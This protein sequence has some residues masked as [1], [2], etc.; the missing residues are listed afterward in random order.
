MH[1]HSSWGRAALAAVLVTAAGALGLAATAPPAAAG[2]FTLTL[3]GPP[4]PPRMHR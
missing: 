4:A 3:T 2:T 1:R